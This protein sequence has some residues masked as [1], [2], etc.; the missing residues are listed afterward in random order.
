MRNLVLGL[1]LVVVFAGTAIAQTCSVRTY[2]GS[3]DTTGAIKA[4]IIQSIDGARTSL[5]IT[6]IH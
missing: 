5:D 2:F 4:A 1:A 6:L 3:P